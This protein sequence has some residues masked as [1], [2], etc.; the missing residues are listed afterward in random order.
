[1]VVLAPIGARRK[2]AWMGSWQ[3]NRPH[4]GL[5]VQLYMGLSMR[6]RIRLN[7]RMWVKLPVRHGLR[8]HHLRY[9]TVV[10][11]PALLAMVPAV[12]S[13][14]PAVVNSPWHAINDRRGPHINHLRLLI[15]DLRLL[16]NNLGLLI[17]HL[18]LA[19]NNLRLWVNHLGLLVNN[20]RLLVNHLRR[21][22]LN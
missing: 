7:R 14:V 17:H 6:L 15:D 8:V 18:R 2:P 9:G 5:I 13:R 20:L 16:V 10:M 4:C 12:P 21:G 1:M 3:L 22:H 11:P 19:V